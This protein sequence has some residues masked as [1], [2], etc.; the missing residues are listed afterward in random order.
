MGGAGAPRCAACGRTFTWEECYLARST[1][2]VEPPAGRGAWGA[3]TYC[4]GCGAVVSEW[5]VGDWEGGESWEWHGANAPLNARG[6]LPPPPILG[7]WGRDI[8]ARL[9]PLHEETALDVAAVAR[10]VAEVEV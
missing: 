3:R 7:G 4:P 8:P 5:L 6:A 10:V 2:G 9:V 1:P